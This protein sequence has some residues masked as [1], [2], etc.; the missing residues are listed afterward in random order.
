MIQ[1]HLTAERLR[2]VLH[3][4]SATGVFTWK[5]RSNRVK[6]ADKYLG[7]FATAAEANQVYLKAK[8]QL[9]EGCTI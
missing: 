2:E 3:Y 4:D 7:C 5:V 9:H 1:E 8:R 6:G